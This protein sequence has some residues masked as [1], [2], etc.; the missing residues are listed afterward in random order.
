M[1][2]SRV[3]DAIRRMARTDP[4][5]DD[6]IEAAVNR[7]AQGGETGVGQDDQD[8]RQCCDGS[9]SDNV[10]PGTSQADPDS[11][12]QDASGGLDPSD[13]AN[14][15]MGAGSLTGLTDCA[16]GEPVC[17]E[18]DGFVP[19]DG[20]E[21]PNKPALDPTYEEGHF[22][23]YKSGL[24]GGTGV[25]CC[26]MSLTQSQTE[27]LVSSGACDPPNWFEN[28]KI[29]CDEPGLASTCDEFESVCNPSEEDLEAITESE[30]P[31]DGC[32]NLAIKSGTIVG[33]KYDPDQDGSY[34]KPLAEIELCD[35]NGNKVGIKPS[36]Q[37]DWK[38]INA[39]TGEDGY[40]YV[41]RVQKAH[42]DG[43]EYSD[44]TM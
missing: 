40:L 3:R 27:S 38:T 17:F 10:N 39:V 16:T 1:S 41:D 32:V 20:W 2:S 22:W 8:D 35:G 15:N 29:S 34:S 11:G 28:T 24:V 21:D 5:L 30:W 7:G 36:G 4:R 19:P 9:V 43:K 37:S 12:G 23:A 33:S 14:L 6:K 26:S 31:S 18:G 44:P 25:S 13:P 42:I